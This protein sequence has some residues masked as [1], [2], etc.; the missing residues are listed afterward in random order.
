MRVSPTTSTIKNLF[1]LSDNRCAFPGCTQKL[2]DE[3]DNIFAQICHI[4]A[5]EPGCD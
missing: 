3:N 2:V 1:A 5:A 4:E